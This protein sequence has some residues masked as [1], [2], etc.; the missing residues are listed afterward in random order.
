MANDL[1]TLSPE[2]A[3]LWDTM[4]ITRDHAVIEKT[5]KRIIAFKAKYEAIEAATNVPWYVVGIMDMR[6]AGGGCCKHLHNGDPLT[7]P[8]VQVPANRPSGKGPFTWQDS[9]IDALKIKK[10]DKITAWT[11]EQMAF[12]FEKYNGFGYRAK[13]KNIPSPYLWGGTNHQAPGKYIADHVFSKTVMDPQIGCMPLLKQIAEM[14]G[15]ELVSAYGATSDP[16]ESSPAS[17]RKAEPKPVATQIIEAVKDNPGLVTI[18]TAGTGGAVAATNGPK[19]PEHQETAP[20]APAP[21]SPAPQAKQI[22]PKKIIDTGKEY[23]A[24]AEDAKGLATYGVEAV[25]WASHDGMYPSL[26]MVAG[27]A[28]LFGANWWQRR[29]A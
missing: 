13:D 10:F 18:A 3:T 1:K 11:V 14:E 9:A 7:A 20:S 6:E 29:R 25:K 2:Y 19:A 17:N 27:I 23:K 26:I 22:D 21:S 16:T 15:V 12:C 8:T 24:I 5:A 4:E 28:A